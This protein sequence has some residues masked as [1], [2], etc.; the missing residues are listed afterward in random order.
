MAVLEYKVRMNVISIFYIS[1]SVF[2][3]PSPP[4]ILLLFYSFLL[5]LLQIT[6]FDQVDSFVD[7][8]YQGVYAGHIA[9]PDLGH[10]LGLRETEDWTK[11]LFVI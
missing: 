2:P 8:C 5:Y 1:N 6:V 4:D 11:F 9:I 3:A 7:F 10:I